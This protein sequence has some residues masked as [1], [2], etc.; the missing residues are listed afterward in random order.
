M[1]SFLFPG[2][3]P[4]ST[5]PVSKG[6]LLSSLL[7]LNLGAVLGAFGTF[8]QTYVFSDVSFL[9]YLAVAIFLDTVTGIWASLYLRNHSSNKLRQVF[10][11]LAQYAIALVAVH[12]LTSFKVGG[13]ANLFV[14]YVAPSF[15]GAVYTLMIWA[16]TLSVDE[17]LGK[18]GRGFL[19]K[20]VRKRMDQF[21]ESG[22]VEDEK[23]LSDNNTS[24][25]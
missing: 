1:L 22:K 4:A 23:A 21:I 25:T 19:P 20:W 24:T 17:N 13:E 2:A 7:A 12:V 11:K 5:A 3:S 8:F 10:S 15:K 14:T 9:G 18:M 16:E 6:A